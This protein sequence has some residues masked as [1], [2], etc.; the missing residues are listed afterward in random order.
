MMEKPATNF[1]DSGKPAWQELRNLFDS[2][3]I[4][5]PPQHVL[6]ELSGMLV[7]ARWGKEMANNKALEDA[8]ILAVIDAQQA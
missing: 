5:V 1:E 6:D 8:L 7:W 4:D 2:S 3:G